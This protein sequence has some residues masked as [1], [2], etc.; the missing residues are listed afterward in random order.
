[1]TIMFITYSFLIKG[2]AI[3]LQMRGGEDEQKHSSTPA[4]GWLAYRQARV[5]TKVAAPSVDDPAVL[6]KTSKEA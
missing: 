2:K 5:R 4:P 1:M 6:E 3:V